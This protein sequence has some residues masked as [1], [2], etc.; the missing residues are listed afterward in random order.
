MHLMEKLQQKMLVPCSLLVLFDNTSK[1]H[2][3]R[4]KII[5]S[6]NEGAMPTS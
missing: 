6:D 2:S 4:V 1:L 3:G 5:A